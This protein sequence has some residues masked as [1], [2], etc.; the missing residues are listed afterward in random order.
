MSEQPGRPGP[1]KSHA[2]PPRNRG[3]SVL[4]RRLASEPT[5]IL[6]VEDDFLIALELETGLTEAGFEVVGIAATAEE[7]LD[8]AVSERP[9]VVVMDVR[10]AGKR[11][12]VDAAIDILR[13]TGVRS[14][15]A[16][17]NQDPR[18]KA[19]GAH[20]QPLAWLSKP[21]QVEIVA[22]M[23]TRFLAEEA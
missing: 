21:Y 2:P 3:S 4:D 7:A 17:A 20:A 5:R 19:R 13:A 18:I 11:D 9:A 14:I 8:M 1:T 12:G 15:F 23:I 6:V 22:A 10:L 16:T